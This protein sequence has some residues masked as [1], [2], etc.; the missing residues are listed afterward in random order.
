V[1]EEAQDLRCCRATTAE[2][3]QLGDWGLC[4]V[5]FQPGQIALDLLA[6]MEWRVELSAGGRTAILTPPD[7]PPS[8]FT[9]GRRSTRHV[10]HWHK[11]VDSALPPQLSFAFH[12]SDHTPAGPIGGNLR[13]FVAALQAVPE[14][15][16]AFHAGRSD[17]SRWLADVYRDH[18]LGSLVETAEHDLVA[19]GD[20]DRTRRLLTELVSF[21]YLPPDQR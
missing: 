14:D 9:L 11:Y 19:H 4:L 12:N 2:P 10:R 6:R 8:P 21:R 17:F 5:S 7:G 13:E 16:I 20:P 15:V 18:V 1:L 3:G